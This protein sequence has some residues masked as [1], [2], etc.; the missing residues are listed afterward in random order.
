MKLLY[1]SIALLFLASCSFADQEDYDNMAKDLCECYSE[2]GDL[3]KCKKK[4]ETDYG[5]L[6]TSGSEEETQEMIRKAFKKQKDC[7]IFGT[8]MSG[9]MPAP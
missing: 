1:V 2:S 8:M 3:D 4:L 7:G 9:E 6:Y 5:D